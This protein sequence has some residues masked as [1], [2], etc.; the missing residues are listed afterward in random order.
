VDSAAGGPVHGSP[1]VPSIELFVFAEPTLASTNGALERVLVYDALISECLEDRLVLLPFALLSLGFLRGRWT[2]PT[3]CQTVIIAIL[4]AGRFALAWKR[5][6]SAKRF[7]TG[8]D[9][10]PVISSS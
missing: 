6:W 4:T 1:S 8:A 9:A 7:P 3:L 5:C 2:A 10:D